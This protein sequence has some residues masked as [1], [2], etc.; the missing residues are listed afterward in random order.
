VG[1]GDVDIPNSVKYVD[2][3]QARAT[4]CAG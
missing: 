3:G 4:L 2:F 1:T